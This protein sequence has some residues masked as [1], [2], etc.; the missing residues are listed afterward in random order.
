MLNLDVAPAG[1]RFDLLF[2]RED[3]V[4]YVGVRR[5]GEAIY[6]SGLS[7]R[8]CGK[9]IAWV[10]DRMSALR[11]FRW[12]PDVRSTRPLNM[13]VPMWPGYL[14]G[15]VV[16]GWTFGFVRTRWRASP[17]ASAVSCSENTS[18]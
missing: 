11:V 1:E 9:K 7:P 8:V 6:R 2:N 12:L 15:L 4:Y 5:K 3:E 18:A 16:A 10:D 17:P 13:F 14:P